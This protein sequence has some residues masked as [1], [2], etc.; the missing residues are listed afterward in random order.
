MYWSNL[1]LVCIWFHPQGALHWI[2]YRTFRTLDRLQ[3]RS[4]LV[5]KLTWLLFWFTVQVSS[6]LSVSLS[7]SPYHLQMQMYHDDDE[8]QRLTSKQ[9]IIGYLFIFSLSA[10]TAA[11][12][13]HKSEIS[14]CVCMCWS[15]FVWPKTLSGYP[16]WVTESTICFGLPFEATFQLSTILR[17]SRILS[18]AA[19][20]KP[21]L[22]CCRSGKT[23]FS[24]TKTNCLLSNFPLIRLLA[25]PVAN[26]PESSVTSIFFVS[27]LLDLLSFRQSH[28]SVTI[29]G[30]SGSGGRRLTGRF[31]FPYITKSGQILTS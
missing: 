14:V 1:R 23:F 11:A 25:I 9:A 16:V 3:C 26:G 21:H 10:I 15:G 24:L 19:S 5:F 12:A 20:R 8:P 28:A 4:H 18:F 29:D 13:F 30:F 6:L 22:R 17:E 27:L 2:D 31:P 7:L